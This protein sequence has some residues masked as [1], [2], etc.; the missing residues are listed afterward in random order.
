MKLYLAIVQCKKGIHVCF[1]LVLGDKFCQRDSCKPVL[2]KAS[3]S[4]LKLNKHNLAELFTG[5][6]LS[7][8][9]HTNTVCIMHSDNFFFHPSG[10]ETRQCKKCAHVCD[11]A[12]NC[13]PLCSLCHSSFPLISSS[14]FSFCT[15]GL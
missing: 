13:V 15:P 8:T 6:K 12:H 3:F 5:W 4:Y 7:K 2:I 14:W 11:C 9:L 1:R 10:N